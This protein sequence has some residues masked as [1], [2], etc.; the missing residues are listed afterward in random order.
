[1]NARSWRHSGESGPDVCL[2]SDEGGCEVLY[3]LVVPVLRYDNVVLADAVE[4][5]ER[6][7]RLLQVVRP[8]AGQDHDGRCGPLE[9]AEGGGGGLV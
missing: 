3:S 7:E 4:P 9:C 8:L 5:H 6:V 2:A 1:M